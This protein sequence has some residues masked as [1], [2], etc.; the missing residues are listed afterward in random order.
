[1]VTLSPS[2]GVHESKDSL[3]RLN[4]ITSNSSFLLLLPNSF[5]PPEFTVRLVSFDTEAE[6]QLETTSWAKV[7]SGVLF[8]HS[9]CRRESKTP[10]C[11]L[12]PYDRTPGNLCRD[13]L[14]QK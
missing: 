14:Q 7:G 3:I 5:L 2:S 4:M 11:I 10:R 13:F 1:M 9:I 6:P 12:S 8:T